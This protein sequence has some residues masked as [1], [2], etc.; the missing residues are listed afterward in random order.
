MGGSGWWVSCASLGLVGKGGG[1]AF[2][3][4]KAMYLV[5]ATFK[6][7]YTIILLSLHVYNL[8]LNVIQYPSF[9]II[10]IN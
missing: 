7:F 1:P 3:R 2:P 9:I 6:V 8:F 4:S 5:L 10:Y